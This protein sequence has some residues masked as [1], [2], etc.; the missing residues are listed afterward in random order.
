[1]TKLRPHF[2]G[3]KWSILIVQ[4]LGL[5][6]NGVDFCQQFNGTIRTSL[7]ALYANLRCRTMLP[8][9]HTEALRNWHRQA[10]AAMGQN[11]ALVITNYVNKYANTNDVIKYV[12]KYANKWC[13]Q[14]YNYK[15][16]NQLS[17][18]TWYKQIC[19]H[20]WCKQICNHKWCTQIYN[21]KWCNQICNH[22]WLNQICN[23]KWCNQ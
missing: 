18:H 2:S 14:I 23:H 12:I 13:Y 19:N 4:K 10:Q 8:V 17:N 22:N 3:L 15:W 6:K 16:C 5:H 7:T 20:K 9:T 1:M 21:H 11:F